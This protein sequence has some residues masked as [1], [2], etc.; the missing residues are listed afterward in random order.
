MTLSP[1]LP[2]PVSSVSLVTATGT[3]LQLRWQPPL[4]TGGFESLPYVVK[5]TGESVTD[6]VAVG[7]S[8]L[9]SISLTG[10]K[11]ATRSA[12]AEAIL[13]S[14]LIFVFGNPVCWA[15]YLLPSSQRCTYC[16]PPPPVTSWKWR[17]DVL[18]VK[19]IS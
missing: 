10:L 15:T 2:D 6:K 4:D 12:L 13:P 19:A 16:F 17:H 5:F 11:L 18:R 14:P 8:L 1:K 3:G 7:S 9:P